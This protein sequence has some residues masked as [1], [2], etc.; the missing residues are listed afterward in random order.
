MREEVTFYVVVG[1]NDLDGVFVRG[2]FSDWNKAMD[3]V[4]VDPTLRVRKV[5]ALKESM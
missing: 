2:I 5:T 4:D 1:V 3:M